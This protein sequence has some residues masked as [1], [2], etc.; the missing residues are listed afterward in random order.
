MNSIMCFHLVLALMR[1]V[2]VSFI[3]G[4]EPLPFSEEDPGWRQ[5]SSEHRNWDKWLSRSARPPSVAA[6]TLGARG[7]RPSPLG[8]TACRQGQSLGEWC[9]LCCVLLSLQFSSHWSQARVV[10]FHEKF[11]KLPAS[12]SPP[13]R[14][15]L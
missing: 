7:P 14:V 1:S 8:L 6:G 11:S 10:S 9:P 4:S 13:S 2:Q 12:D 15:I 5:V 3:P